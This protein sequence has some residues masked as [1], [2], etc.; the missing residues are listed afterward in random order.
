MKRTWVKRLSSEDGVFKL[1]GGKEK[2]PQ[3]AGLKR[4]LQMAIEKGV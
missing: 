1:V 2:R 3:E 4:R